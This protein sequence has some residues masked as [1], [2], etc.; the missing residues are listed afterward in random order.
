MK[1]KVLAIVPAAG[2][3]RR[4]GLDEKKPFI[5]LAGKPLGEKQP[6]PPLAPRVWLEGVGLGMGG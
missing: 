4:M 1:S 2:H 6:P 5:P 3:G